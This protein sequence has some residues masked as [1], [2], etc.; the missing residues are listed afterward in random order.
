MH[1]L[2]LCGGFVQVLEIMCM[3]IG[4]N[5]LVPSFIQYHPDRHSD[6]KVKVMDVEIFF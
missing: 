1:A 4:G 2:G 5:V 3:W 6:L